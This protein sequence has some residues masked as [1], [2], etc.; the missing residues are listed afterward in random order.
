MDVICP[1]GRFGASHQK[2]APPLTPRPPPQK[3]KQKIDTMHLSTLSRGIAAT[4]LITTS[5]IP[6]H[7]CLAEASEPAMV[8]PRG[9]YCGT[10]ELFGFVHLLIELDF[11]VDKAFDFQVLSTDSDYTEVTAVM[12]EWC[13]GN[14]YEVND[15]VAA[16]TEPTDCWK[17][18]QNI[19]GM[20]A[21]LNVTWDDDDTD[22]PSIEVVLANVNQV[23]RRSP[24]LSLSLSLFD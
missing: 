10:Y 23:R 8:V 22:D 15:G 21:T 7:G 16:N 11:R 1:V 14:A 4:L 19:I 12:F 6:F 13:Y 2:A 5:L 20:G 18:L 3:K 17:N 9:K 24:I